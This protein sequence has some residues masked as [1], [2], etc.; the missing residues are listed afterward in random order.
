MLEASIWNYGTHDGFVWETAHFWSEV[1]LHMNLI[2]NSVTN[3]SKWFTSEAVFLHYLIP[4]QT[5]KDG[6]YE[7]LWWEMMNVSK[8]ESF[9]TPGILRWA[10][11]LLQWAHL[12]TEIKDRVCR[13]R[14]PNFPEVGSKQ[15]KCFQ[16]GHWTSLG[17]K[18]FFHLERERETGV[19]H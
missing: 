8:W 4:C 13:D 14:I 5:A 10:S 11:G 7:L 1:L 19:I 12:R 3:R 9:H 16:L 17:T 2:L 15:G 6:F 18:L